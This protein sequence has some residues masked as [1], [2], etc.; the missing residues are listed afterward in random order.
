MEQADTFIIPAENVANVSA[1]NSLYHAMLVL[2][3]VKYSMIP[4][5]EKN[6]RFVGLVGLANVMEKIFEVSPHELNPENL[7]EYTVADVMVEAPVITNDWTVEEVLHLLV[8][9]SFIP[10]VD[11]KGIFCGILTRKQMLK[12]LNH[13]AHE[14]ERRNVVLPKDEVHHENEGKVRIVIE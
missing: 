12:A 2:T 13:M 11:D 3:Q 8:E 1:N 10:V 9:H 7:K 6:D 14:L 5:L 4:V